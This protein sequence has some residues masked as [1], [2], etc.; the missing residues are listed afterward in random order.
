MTRWTTFPPSSGSPELTGSRHSR[1]ADSLQDRLGHRFSDRSLLIE[2]LSH[3]SWCSENPG[4]ASNERLEFLGDSVVG[5][6]VTDRLFRARPNLPE[7]EMT[8][9]RA[10]VVSAAT[11]G[12]VARELGLG[13]AVLLGRG[14]ETSGGR[15]KQSILCD[16]MEAVIGAVYL[17]GGFGDAT[18]LVQRLLIGP[19][20]AALMGVPGGQDHKTRLQERT[21]HL[22]L[23]MPSYS[24]TETGPD[25]DKRFVATVSVAGEVLGSGGGRSKKQAEQEAAAVAFRA[26]ASRSAATTT[27]T[28][29]EEGA[30][31]NA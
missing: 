1:L 26:L 31:I 7:G 29:E 28:D 25:H 17:D 2:A 6:A 27:S 8:K 24:Y 11:L 21:T 10:T 13:E 15:D 3:R 4:T 14:E 20:E 18:A 23:G 30:P 22:G 9:I 12:K 5:I 19:M 16:A